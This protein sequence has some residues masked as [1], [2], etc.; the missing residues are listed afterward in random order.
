M[1]FAVSDKLKKQIKVEFEQLEYLLNTYEPLLK[2]CISESLD[3]IEISAL[4]AMLHAFYTGIENI[5][6]R[7]STELDGGLPKTEIWHRT[8]LNAM[9]LPGPIRPPVISQ[10]LKDAL[11]GYLDFRHVFRHAYTFDLRWAKMAGLVGECNKT[12]RKLKED[13]TAFFIQ[14]DKSK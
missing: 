9:A 12:Y 3:P 5:F 11:R 8:L 10:N 6:K 4:A 14:I 2:K 1:N 13:I 7:V